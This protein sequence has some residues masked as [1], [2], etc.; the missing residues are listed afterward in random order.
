MIRLLNN[1]KSNK[2]MESKLIN[3]KNTYIYPKKSATLHPI[4]LQDWE[5]KIFDVIKT[6]LAKYNKKTICRVAG[7]WVRDKVYHNYIAF[8]KT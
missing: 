1:F 4:H 3:I 8:R 7:G 2:I 5:I 6:T